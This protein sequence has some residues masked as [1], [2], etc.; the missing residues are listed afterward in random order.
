MQ[1]QNICEQVAIDTKQVI[2]LSIVALPNGQLGTRD[3]RGVIKRWGMDNRQIRPNIETVYPILNGGL[4]A[5]TNGEL[6]SGGN[7]GNLRRWGMDGKQIGPTINTI[8]NDNR[9]YSLLGLSDGDL[10]TG[11]DVGILTSWGMDGKQVGITVE[12]GQT[13]LWFL[14]EPSDGQLVSAGFAAVSL[15]TWGKGGKQLGPTINTGHNISSLVALPNG[16]I[17]SGGDDGTLKL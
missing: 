10:A 15:K 2:L 3:S 5:M 8:T 14:V 11:T 16:E 9:M 6:V 1:A 12:T 13:S 17:A 7:N 4:V